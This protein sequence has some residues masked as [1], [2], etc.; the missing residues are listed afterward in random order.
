MTPKKKSVEDR[1][2]EL[3]TAIRHHDYLYHVKDAPEISD[4]AYD[5]MFRDLKALEEQSPKLSTPDSPTQ[6]VGGEPFDRFPS[7]EHAAP[8]LSLDSDKEEAVLRKFDDRIRKCLRDG[9]H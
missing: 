9:V 8:M 1:V 3:R 7:V 5:A 4:D 6:R 2:R